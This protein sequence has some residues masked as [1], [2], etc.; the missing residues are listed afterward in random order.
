M[1][2]VILKNNGIIPYKSIPKECQLSKFGNNLTQM[3]HFTRNDKAFIA[4]QI[5]WYF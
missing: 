2:S 1:Y 5:L 3:S 4:T